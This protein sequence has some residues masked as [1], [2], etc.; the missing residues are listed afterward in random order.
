[1]KRQIFRVGHAE[2]FQLRNNDDATTR[3]GTVKE[4][5]GPDKIFGL[6]VWMD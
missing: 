3:Q 5:Q 6:A 1:M 4:P 2:I